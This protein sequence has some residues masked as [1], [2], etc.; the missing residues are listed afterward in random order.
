L[1]TSAKHSPQVGFNSNVRYRG[2]TFHIQTEDSGRE[3]PRV[4]TLL[5]A[6]GGHIIASQRSE[7]QHLLAEPDV[8]VKL[9]Q[10]MQDQH[11]AVLRELASGSL[12]DKI[13][14]VIGPL[15]P[16]SSGRQVG[17]GELRLGKGSVVDP[18]L[19]V[20]GERPAANA[21]RVP[22]LA[23]PLTSVTSPEML[24]VSQAGALED[25]IPSSRETSAGVSAV[26]DDEVRRVPGLP[27]R[28]S[29]RP[30]AIDGDERVA[31]A[32]RP[33]AVFEPSGSSLFGGGA[34]TEG[35][36]NDVILSFIAQELEDLPKKGG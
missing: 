35:S 21:S 15:A 12:D 4:T 31:K 30:G 24:V 1:S 13:E 25:L 22:T 28:I 2:N 20:M 33:A 16:R 3:R 14:S 5:F 11:R 34:L 29:G 17:S 27:R 10:Q 36:L 23:A 7:Y 26:V 18:L 19:S 8:A 9:K 32:T 6:D